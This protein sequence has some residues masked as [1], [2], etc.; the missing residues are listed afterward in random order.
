M[1]DIF[2]NLTDEYVAL[3]SVLVTVLLF[4]ISRFNE[5][6]F[7]KHELKKEKYLEFIDLLKET[8]LSGGKISLD[9][10]FKEKF[11]EFGA[12]LFIYGSKK[13]YKKYCFF[14]EIGN[15][16][17]KKTKYYDESIPLFLVADILNQ[18]RKEIGMYTFEVPLNLKSIAFFTNDIYFNPTISCKWLNY[19]LRYF[20]IK[21][22]LFL[23]KIDEMTLIKNF[24]SFIILPFQIFT[25]IFKCLFQIPL[26]KFLVKIGLDKK[27][28]D[29][30]NK[31][32]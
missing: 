12:T 31:S 23:Y 4:I 22:E 29:F 16:I 27:I 30:Y 18:I 28:F 10:D 2:K 7:K 8:Y 14:R 32:N 5:L 1:L 19:K 11:F 17:V 3:I 26:G 9:N 20:L 15:D 24:I 21:F 6:K 13:I 25:L